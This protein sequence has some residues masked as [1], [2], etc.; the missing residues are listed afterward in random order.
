MCYR[1]RYCLRKS[2]S[3]VFCYMC[4]GLGTFRNASFYCQMDKMCIYIER[5]RCCTLRK[6]IPIISDVT[7]VESQPVRDRYLKTNLLSVET[8]SS[9]NV[10]GFFCEGAGT[11]AALTSLLCLQSMLPSDKYNQALSLN[12]NK[13]F[14]HIFFPKRI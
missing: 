5:E 10:W 2:K 12:W 7:N 4:T 11:S 14:L 3:N 6:H 8:K 1:S 9:W 13:C